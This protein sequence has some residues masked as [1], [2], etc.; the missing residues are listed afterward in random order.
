MLITES[1]KSAPGEL[2]RVPLSSSPPGNHGNSVS[3]LRVTQMLPL[4]LS[5]HTG[6]WADMQVTPKEPLLGS[7]S[8]PLLVAGSITTSLLRLFT[9][10]G[11]GLK[12]HP[13]YLSSP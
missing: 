13:V 2:N 11:V 12:M 8:H 5:T 1:F 10:H 3:Y 7:L 9:A 6:L 4:V